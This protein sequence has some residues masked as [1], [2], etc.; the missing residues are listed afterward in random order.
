[1]PPSRFYGAGDS[2]Q[3]RSAANAGLVGQHCGVA[4]RLRRRSIA[5]LERILAGCADDDLT[6]GPTGLSLGD[7]QSSEM[8]RR[9]WSV[10]LPAASFDQAKSAI[11]GWR[12]HRGAGLEVLADGA[13]AVGTNVAMCAHFRS[14][15]ST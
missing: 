7:P 15:T 5:D 11:Q 12:V 2:S 14:A 10:D 4:I 1:M 13:I 9:V 8:T 3:A 6:Y